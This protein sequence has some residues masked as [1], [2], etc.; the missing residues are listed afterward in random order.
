MCARRCKE[1]K[2][3]SLSDDFDLSEG[4]HYKNSCSRLIFCWFFVDLCYT[5]LNYADRHFLLTP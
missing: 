5:G 2:A 1:G 4:V 3:F